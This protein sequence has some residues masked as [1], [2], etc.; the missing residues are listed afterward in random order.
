MT[1]PLSAEALMSDVI[2]FAEMGDH[3]TASFVDLA[4]SDWIR[5]ELAKAGFT[6]ELGPMVPAPVPG[7][8]LRLARV[9]HGL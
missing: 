8:R 9:R 4:T 5:S 2:H 6:A 7:Y 3:R 1:N